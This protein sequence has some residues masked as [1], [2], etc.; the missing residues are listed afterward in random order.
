MSRTNIDYDL[1]R[2]LKDIIKKFV[3]KEINEYSTHG[4]WPSIIVNLLEG[5]GYEKINFDCN[6]WQWDYWIT[7]TKQGD[8]HE[9]IVDKITISGSGYYGNFGLSREQF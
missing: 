4:I 9:G 2:D 7:M 1:L 8:Y 6:G 3:N 5:E